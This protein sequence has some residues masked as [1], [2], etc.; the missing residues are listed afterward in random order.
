MDAADIGDG[1][2]ARRLQQ[3]AFEHLD[4]VE[5]CVFQYLCVE[6]QYFRD[7]VRTFRIIRVGRGF[8]PTNSTV[9]IRDAHH[10]LRRCGGAAARAMLK[11]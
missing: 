3:P 1:A 6:R 8:A 11:S 5:A 9:S 4:V 7:R 2:T 10:T